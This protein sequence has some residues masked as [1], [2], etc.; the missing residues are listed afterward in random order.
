MLANLVAAAILVALSGYALLGGADFGGGVWDALASGPRRDRQRALIADAI[1]PV[2]EANHV[3]LV[4]VVVLLFTGFPPAFAELATVLHVPLT[5]VLV[6]I[7]LRGSAFT[8]RTYDSQRSAV[9]RRWGM[10]FSAASIITPLFLGVCV[11]A[12][13]SGKVGE[14]AALARLTETCAATRLPGPTPDSTEFCRRVIEGR[15]AT[16]ADIFV[17][18]WFT[19]FAVSIG[20]L[21]LALFAFLAAVY[22]TVEARDEA[23]REDFRR[24]ALGAAGA[25]FVAAFAALLSARGGAPLMRRGLTG[26]AWAL[27]FH[28][29]TGV[30]AVGAIWSLWTRR[31]RLARVAA[32]AQVLFILWGWAASQLP[33]LIPPR[34]T[35]ADAA[36]PDATL[37]LVL[38]ALAAGAVVLFPSLAYLFRVFKRGDT[39]FERVDAG[40]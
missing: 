8:F 5:L 36:A 17:V 1:A 3:W 18:P 16:F 28:V 39:A 33:Y 25:V 24:R 26:S 2:W 35:I 7:V 9:Q 14:A 19:P 4:I 11:G 6:G 30:A 21:A 29:V 20:V 40:R 22:L 13:A 10:I 34:V 23:L 32:A 38:W 12:I 31:W 15:T 37:S 27:P